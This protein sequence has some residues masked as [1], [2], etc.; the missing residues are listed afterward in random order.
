MCFPAQCGGGGTR[1]FLLGGVGD[2]HLKN[3]STAGKGAKMRKATQLRE[4]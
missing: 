3:S 1:A 2:S 4:E